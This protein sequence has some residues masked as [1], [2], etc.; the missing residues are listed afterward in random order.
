[1]SEKHS[2]SFVAAMKHYFNGMPS[3]YTGKPVDQT[4]TAFLT[5]LK[6]LTDADKAWFREHLATV[7]YEIVAA[8]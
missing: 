8:V 5:E 4:P 3:L 2:M 7:G 6:K 1:M